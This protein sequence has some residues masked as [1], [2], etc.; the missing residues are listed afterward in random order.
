MSLLLSAGLIALTGAEAGQ[1]PA[2]SKGEG[3]REIAP[4][5]IPKWLRKLRREVADMEQTLFRFEETRTSRISARERVFE[6]VVEREG[7]ERLILYYHKPDRVTI[8]MEE[9]EV[10]MQREGKRRRSRDI[11]PEHGRVLRACFALNLSV[12]LEHAEVSA[13]GDLE[14]WTIRAEPDSLRE[15]KSLTLS[16]E[17]SLLRTLEVDAGGGSRRRFSFEPVSVDAVAPQA[18]GAE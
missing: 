13:Q 6:G 15:I 8:T 11:D 18:G 9:D 4:D 14:A 3:L 2:A 16:G 10:S 7:A 17:G 5:N 1:G 12:L